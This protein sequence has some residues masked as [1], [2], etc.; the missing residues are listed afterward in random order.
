MPD[1]N[2][3]NPVFSGL[4][5]NVSQWLVDWR[6]YVAEGVPAQVAAAHRSP[7]HAVTTMYDNAIPI[8]DLPWTRTRS[9][10]WMIASTD[11][12]GPYA[13][14]GLQGSL[15][16]YSIST[17][18][19][20]VTVVPCDTYDPWIHANNI[21]PYGPPKDVGVQAAGFGSLIY[22]ARAGYDEVGPISSIR[23]EHFRKGLE[24]S[25]YFYRLARALRAGRQRVAE[26]LQCAAMLSSGQQALERIHS[27][28]WGWTPEGKE[29]LTAVPF[30]QTNITAPYTTN[31][32]LVEA[33]LH[34]VATAIEGLQRCGFKSD[35]GGPAV[36]ASLTAV[37][38]SVVPNAGN[39][40]LTVQGAGFVP[41]SSTAV[42][43]F[44]YNA[45]GNAW[46]ASGSLWPGQPPSRP[47]R[48]APTP[49]PTTPATVH[50]S[51]HL[52]CHLPTIRVPFGTGP[53]S[54]GS[55]PNVTECGFN[56]STLIAGPISIDISMDGKTFTGVTA[57]DPPQLTL[58]PLFSASAGQRTYTT[59]QTTAH[60]LLDV[61]RSLRDELPQLT[62]ELDCGPGGPA[63]HLPISQTGRQAV[64]IPLPQKTV[65]CTCELHGDS[66][67]L[68]TAKI[69]L[70][71]ADSQTTD[72]PVLV[73]RRR[74]TFLVDGA[75]F[76]P[77]GWVTHAP[78]A[79]AR[80]PQMHLTS[81]GMNNYMHYFF[82]KYSPQAQAEYST[83][84][85]DAAQLVSKTSLRCN[86][87]SAPSNIVSLRTGGV[88][89]G[90]HDRSN[91]RLRRE[92]DRVS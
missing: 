9:F 33:V 23:W 21:G 90:I 55:D 1:V 15:S 78:G 64:A 56:Q 91:H 58:Q 12:L 48:L 50:N 29:M 46:G 26:S 89:A 57:Q 35:D 22:P 5:R 27:V 30:A 87:S 4:T 60:L 75:P 63:L 47:P 34:D 42:C 65:E 82:A 44:F 71:I 79:S 14:A 19:L 54:C 3:S 24:D 39:T 66:G 17:W 73:D 49:D 25:E 7:A 13:G 51:T 41:G 59:D 38:P 83:L 67:T 31:V 45:E 92:P 80:A 62:V 8:I 43:K 37:A 74:R 11:V 40:L 53:H 68:G 70:D 77:F 61:H 16:W 69:K 36:G 52:T 32:T 18:C 76:L 81:L 6:Q 84:M 28:V 86:P 20:P 10:P 2:A 72:Y 88:G 85:D